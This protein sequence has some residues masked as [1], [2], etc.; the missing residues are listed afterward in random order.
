M[1]A[2]DQ[3]DVTD[4]WDLAARPEAL[5]RAA[6]AWRGIGAD[7]RSAGETLDRAAA[8]VV[9]GAW[10]GAAAEGYRAQYRHLAESL[11]ELTRA[12]EDTAAA[13]AGA[14][15]LLRGG[16]EQLDRAWERVAGAVA[17]RRGGGTVTFRPA[18]EGQ[19]AAVRAAIDAAG[20]VRA[21]V[22]RGLA[23]QDAALARARAAWRMLGDEWTLRLTGVIPVWTPPT[24]TGLDWRRVGDLF[25]V[26]TGAE[27]DSVIV[28]DGYVVLGRERVAIPA[29]TRLV[30]RTGAGADSVTVTSR[31]GATVLGGDGDDRLDGGDGDGDDRII[32]GQG[33][34]LV[35]AGAGADR[36]SLG[37]LDPHGAARESTEEGADLGAGDDLLWGS[38]GNESDRG[39]EGADV[40]PGRRRQRLPRRRRGRRHDH[41]RLRRRHALRPRR[42]RR[43]ARRRRRR[44][45]GGRRRRRPPRRR[46]GPRRALRRLRR[47][48]AG[49]QGGRGRAVH[50]CGP[51]RRRR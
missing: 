4:V 18:D 12:A 36:V 22:E 34:D 50:G 1:R 16:Q 27:A 7:A 48:P 47:R 13:L 23:D 30:L 31:A 26:Q 29:G 21:D 11:E 35:R 9:G 2:A 42:R 38:R 15:A 19:A 40:L 20:A 10:Q 41:R 44:L 5:G 51:R 43:P 6:L 39:G 28:E 17:H 33:A 14:G 37:P 49:R 3:I 25:V 45:P 24:E 8:P 32:A 46:R